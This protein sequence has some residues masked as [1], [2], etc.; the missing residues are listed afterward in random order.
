MT[1][2]LLNFTTPDGPATV[3]VEN[4]V[5]AGWTG[6]DKAAL[7]H[8]IEELAAIGVPGPS[9]VPLYYRVAVEQVLQR[10]SVQVLGGDSSGEV[11]PVL[12]ATENGLLLTVGSDHTDRKVESYSIPVSK[13]MCPKVLATTAWPVKLGSWMDRLTIE[14][15]ALIDGQEVVYQSGTL[16]MIRPLAELIDG[17]G[18]LKPG[19]VMLCG[20]VPVVGGLRHADRFSMRLADPDTGAAVEHTYSIE[21]LPVVL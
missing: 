7:D 20:T 10:T 14:S 8:H 9:T 11:E 13:Q 3:A 6:R 21:T 2:R 16:A 17:Y 18:G 19:T 4:C 15:R 12:I 1:M 5:V